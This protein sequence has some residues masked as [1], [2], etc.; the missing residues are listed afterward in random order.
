MTIGGVSVSEAMYLALARIL[1]QN[2]VPLASINARTG[3]TLV[4]R[5]YAEIFVPDPNT[6]AQAARGRVKFL[7]LTTAGQE[8]IRG[9]KKLYN[10]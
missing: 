7:R 4:T 8:A 6:W 5:G 10:R 9:L 1:K 2:W 3:R